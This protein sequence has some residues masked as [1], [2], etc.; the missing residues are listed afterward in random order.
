MRELG[1]KFSHHSDPKSQCL[2]YN[3]S[4]NSVTD[5]AATAKT[6][7]FSFYLIHS[8][9]SQTIVRFRIIFVCKYSMASNSVR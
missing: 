9:F 6:K 2:G 1:Y 4:Q 7:V 5:L 8:K 3:F